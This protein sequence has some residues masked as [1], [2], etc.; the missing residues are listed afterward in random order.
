MTAA[1]GLPTLAMMQAT[2]VPFHVVR[3]RLISMAA[4]P[5]LARVGPSTVEGVFQSALNLHTPAGLLTVVAPDRGPWPNGITLA[6]PVDFVACGLRT[7]MS[8]L[9]GDRHVAIPAIDLRLILDGAAAWNPRLSPTHDMGAAERWRSRVTAVRSMAS[10]MI[11]GSPGR[12]AGLG[13]LLDPASDGSA[14][15]RDPATRVAAEALTVLGSALRDGDVSR[16]RAAADRLIGLGPGLTPSG[17]DA[18]VG[19]A[20]SAAVL[21]PEGASFLA[22]IARDARTRTTS[23]AAALLLHAARGEFAGGLHDLLRALLGRDPGAVRPAVERALAWGATSGADTLVGVF[24]GLDA[25]AA[26]DRAS[27]ASTSAPGS[28]A[29]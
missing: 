14:A 9:V 16:A 1:P 29:A 4:E 24:L 10:G 7:G 25:L 12:G 13:R 11:A 17:D 20:A 18:L 8:V 27:V 22:G 21:G 23:V 3:A 2:S 28:R 26:A 19:V 15:G 5:L 6:T